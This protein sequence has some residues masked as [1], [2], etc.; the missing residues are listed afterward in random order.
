M[1]NEA[2]TAFKII[3][4]LSIVY[5]ASNFFRSSISVIAPDIMR[6][7]SLTHEQLGIV[8]GMFFIAF[9]LFQIPVG[10]LLDRYGPKKT[11][12]GL[13]LIAMIS[14]AGFAVATNFIELALAR[15]FLGIGCSPVLMGSLVII[16]RWLSAERFA[17][18]ASL[19]VG[20][21]G[22]GNIVSTTPTALLAEMAGWRDV[23]WVAGGITAISL[24]FGFMIIKDAPPGHAFHNRQPESLK[25][26][27]ASVIKII[28]DR[29]FQY[30]FAINL[31]IYGAV[32]TIVALWGSHYLHDIYG[33][34]LAE[35]GVILFWMTVSMIAGSITYGW[36]DGIFKNRKHLI[37]GAAVASIVLFILLALI[38]VLAVWQI[39]FLLILLCFVGSYGVVI[40]SHGRAIFPEK[41]LGRGIATL[42]TAVFLGVFL[43]QAMG[44]FIVGFFVEDD[45]SAPMI[46]YRVLF[47]SIAAVVVVALAIYSRSRDSKTQLRKITEPETTA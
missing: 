22:L 41:L 25:D 29:E 5:V 7:L 36:L 12:C 47:V 10:I 3:A 27:S 28:R 38:P 15:F 24:I 45:G 26:A 16:S 42:N 23:F 44:G 46:A 6:D 35:R 4:T 21:G 17:F 37:M 8:G 34:D 30:V 11:I 18:Y 13:M 39:S 33:L 1:K 20:L 19:V 32:M 31:V 2:G 40:M 14:S 9:A 43:M